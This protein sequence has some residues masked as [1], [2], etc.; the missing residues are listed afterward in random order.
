MVLTT[1][2]ARITLAGCALLAL[3]APP[4]A[5]AGL[6]SDDGAGG[7]GPTVV[8]ASDDGAGGHGPTVVL[9]S[10]DGAGGHGPTAHLD[11]NGEG[12]HG[13]T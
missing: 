11:D 6:A 1:I 2:A 4:V 10:D 12:G 3:S 13:P 9:A 7:H 5:G 8:L